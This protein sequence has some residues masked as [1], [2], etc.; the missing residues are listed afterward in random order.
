MLFCFVF[1]TI[2]LNDRIGLYLVSTDCILIVL[3]SDWLRFKRRLARKMQDTYVYRCHRAGKT[4]TSCKYRYFY[5][6]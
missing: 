5:L 1:E 4:F 2:S 6:L 3:S